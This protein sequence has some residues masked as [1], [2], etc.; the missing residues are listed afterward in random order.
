MGRT[1][2]YG[3]QCDFRLCGGMGY[4]IYIPQSMWGSNGSAVHDTGTTT[5]GI[6]NGAYTLSYN[7]VP[8]ACIAWD[9][10]EG[11]IQGELR[12][13]AGLEDVT[14]VRQGDGSLAWNYG[15]MYE[16]TFAVPNTDAPLGDALDLVVD[17]DGTCDGDTQFPGQIEVS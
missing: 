11:S 12:A 9:E 10:A 7:G 2:Q 17:N 16:V 3:R 8:S 4:N 1:D 5:A 13:I 15:Y 14:V 6:A